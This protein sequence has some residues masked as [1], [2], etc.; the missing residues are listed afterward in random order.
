[1]LA[2]DAASLAEL[3][4]HHVPAFA[5]LAVSLHAIVLALGSGDVDDAAERIN[6]ILDRHPAH[7]HLAKDDGRSRLHHHPATIELVSMWNAI[8]GEALARLIATD[9]HARLGVC[10]APDCHRVYFDE[11][12][13]SSRR[14]CTLACQNRTKTAAFRRRQRA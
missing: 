5:D 2:V 7:P 8:C 6:A 4:P 14:F 10:T 1:M 13:N 11:S 12:K 3:G 9:R